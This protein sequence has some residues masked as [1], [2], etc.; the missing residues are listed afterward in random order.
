MIIIKR[1]MV[2]MLL[3]ILWW[4]KN[5]CWDFLPVKNRKID[6]QSHQ[7]KYPEKSRTISKKSRDRN[8][9]Q[10][11]S[12]KIPGSRDF[13]KIPSRIE[14]PDPAGAW[15]VINF[16][17]PSWGNH[18]EVLDA[19]WEQG[20]FIYHWRCC[21]STSSTSPSFPPSCWQSSPAEEIFHD[22]FPYAGKPRRTWS[23]AH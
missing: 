21:W 7:K 16:M 13:A 12:R 23:G 20:A 14:I 10:I 22:F 19:G 2:M 4:W 9:R 5:V 8:M 18:I 1:M 15:L 17:K 6:H 11:P 3:M